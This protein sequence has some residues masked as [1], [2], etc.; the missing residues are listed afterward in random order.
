MRWSTDAVPP[1]QRL[2]FYASALA[3]ALVP[4]HLGCRAPTEF[5]TE[6]TMADLGL[7]S[8]VH[9]V[10]SPHRAYYADGDLARAAG[11]SY[12]LMINLASPWLVTHRGRVLLKPGDAILSDSALHH[13]LVLESD[14]EVVHVKLSEAWVKQWLPAPGVLV[15]RRIPAESGWGRALTS[16]LAQ[17]SPRFVVDSPLPTSVITDHI[18][19]LLALIADQIGSTK[20]PATRAETD[21]HGRIKDAIVQ[22]CTD[23]G[24]MTQHIAE[25]LSISTRTLH[26]N[27]ASFGE[28]FGARLMDA[29][30]EVAVRMLESPLFR[31]LTV[32]EIGRRSGFA[33][34]SHFSRVLRNRTGRTPTQLR[35]GVQAGDEGE[36][37]AGA[38]ITR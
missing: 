6:M 2:D 12:H 36:A 24:L 3:S 32:A 15:G 33:D 7:L 13:D 14:Y 29:R 19:A 11:R 27:L 17:L 38:E 1:A 8:V 30:A 26:R 23:P 5:R 25:S 4:M 21:L 22:R 18:G 16:Y 10:G 20:A 28:T 35:G 37:S 9:Q 31:R 34:A